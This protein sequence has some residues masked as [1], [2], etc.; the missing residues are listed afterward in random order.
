MNSSLELFKLRSFLISV[1]A[2]DLSIYIDRGT[3]LPY[4]ILVRFC[5]FNRVIPTPA[6]VQCITGSCG[7]QDYVQLR[8]LGVQNT[9]RHSVKLDFSLSMD[10]F[11]SRY[12]SRSITTGLLAFVI[13]N[14]SKFCSIR[15]GL[16]HTDSSGPLSHLILRS[17]CAERSTMSLKN[18]LDTFTWEIPRV[19][20]FQS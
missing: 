1:L 5:S 16:L 20:R 2:I 19:S 7:S 15:S 18:Y 4:S 17:R 13:Q 12:V 8:K 3:L 10:W 14:F 11:A 9:V 6:I